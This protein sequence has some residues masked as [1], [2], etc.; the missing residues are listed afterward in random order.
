MSDGRLANTD[1]LLSSLCVQPQTTI[2]QTIE[3]IDRNAQGIAF[4]IDTARHL[5]G[6][7]S[8]GDVRRAVLAGVNLDAPVSDLVERKRHTVPH[9]PITAPVGTPVSTLLHVMNQQGLRH[10]PLLD[11]EGRLISVALL[12]E[13]VK[14]YELPL[15]AVVMAGGFGT[16]IRPL[17]EQVPKPMLPVGER[18]LLEWMIQQLRQAGIRRVSLTTHYKAD[19]I[20]KHF[21]DGSKFGVG[22]QYI[23]EDG[24]LG[25]AG[26]LSLLE[27]STEPLLVINGDIVTRVDFRAMLDFHR[28]HQA[29]MTVG[30][31]QHEVQLPYG[32][33]EAEDDGRIIGIS[34]KP[35]VRHFINA[36]IYLINPEVCRC[37]P[38]G[39]RYDMPDLIA[40]LVAEQRRVVAFPIRE[41][42]LDIGSPEDYAQARRHM[43]A[44]TLRSEAS[45]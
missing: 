29:H 18:P 4:V 10:I 15:T 35:H 42:W 8:D 19:V 34:E 30:V 13:L 39:R 37:V 33:V 31:R 1:A 12:S 17:T 32:V 22:I 28:E 43:E 36:G 25:T 26:A 27:T 6:T 23:Q 38:S 41:Y 21:G 3:Q 14:E 40:Y 24:P 9:G 44:E 45:T 20:A 16:R 2:R 5:L 7:I 11:A